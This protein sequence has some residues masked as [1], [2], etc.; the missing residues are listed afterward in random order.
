MNWDDLRYFLA[1]AAAG[2]L[3]AAAQQLGVNTTT[4][5]R[6][7]GSLEE[8]LNMRLFDRDRTGYRLTEDGE[9]LAAALEPVDQRL[10]ALRR[11]LAANAHGGAGGL[12]RLAL[13]GDLAAALLPEHLTDFYRRYPEIE[14]EL[15]EDATAGTAP[16]VMSPLRDVDIALRLARPTQG[17]MLVRKLGDIA[18]GLYGARAYLAARGWP[19]T[20]TDVAG[21]D[22]VGFA[23]SDQPLGP[24][25]WLSRAEKSANIVLRASSAEARLAACMQGLGLAALPCYAAD[26]RPELDRVFGPDLLGS[27]ELWL[28]TRNDLAQLPHVRAVMEFMVDTVKAKRVRLEGGRYEVRE[29]PLRAQSPN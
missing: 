10:S 8:D 17:D 12:V 25:W 18:F 7:V 9:K 23:R 16:R 11:D 24:V 20:H 6:R 19:E 27:F 15:L 26:E 4:V 2:S 1:V 29:H 5:L 14:L 13:P 21:H 28:L 3:T 22:I